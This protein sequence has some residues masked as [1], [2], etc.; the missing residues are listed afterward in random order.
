MYHPIDIA[1]AFEDFVFTDE[2]KAGL[3]E[4][5]YQLKAINDNP[6]NSEYWRILYRVI[7]DVADYVQDVWES[8]NED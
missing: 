6:Y 3:E 1:E 4:A 2:E 7:G 5:L 8:E